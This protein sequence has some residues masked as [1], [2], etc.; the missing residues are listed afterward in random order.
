MRSKVIS[1]NVFFLSFLSLLSN[2]IFSYLGFVLS[3]KHRLGHQQSTIGNN[4]DNNNK[5]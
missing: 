5:Q 4:I 1:T 3:H 2:D